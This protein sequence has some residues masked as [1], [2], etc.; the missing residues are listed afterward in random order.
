MWVCETIANDVIFQQSLFKIRQLVRNDT[1]A[2]L[3]LSPSASKDTQKANDA[4]RRNRKI[5]RVGGGGVERQAGKQTQIKKEQTQEHTWADTQNDN[6][7]NISLR[8][9]KS[10]MQ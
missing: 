7:I 5:G 9:C 10:R 1:F 8:T 6:T 2:L 3:G 4:R